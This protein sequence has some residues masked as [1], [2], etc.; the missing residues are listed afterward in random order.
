MAYNHNYLDT[1]GI[2]PEKR[3]CYFTGERNLT[4]F[5][6]TILSINYIHNYNNFIVMI[7]IFELFY[8]KSLS[9]LGI[10]LF[11]LQNGMWNDEKCS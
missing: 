9:I 7:L 2:Q 8:K 11:K 1:R 4:L 10:F 6:V 5:K 3:G